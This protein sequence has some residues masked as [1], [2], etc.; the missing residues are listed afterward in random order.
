M[1]LI[2]QWSRHYAII[3]F[4]RK[5]THKLQMLCKKDKK[6][7]YDEM[8]RKKVKISPSIHWKCFAC[9]TKCL[10]EGYGRFHLVLM[11][12]LDHFLFFDLNSI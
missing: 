5:N 2:T 4:V 3:A 10:I 7:N 8:V 1:N 6:M 11:I 9:L 12:I